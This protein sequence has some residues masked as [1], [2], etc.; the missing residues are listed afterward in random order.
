MKNIARVAVVLIQPEIPGN[1]GTIGRL[2]VGFN[3]EL[4]LIRP[5]GFQI[6]DKSVKRAGLDYWPHLN[7]HI[8]DSWDQ[9]LKNSV[10]EFQQLVLLSKQE[11]YGINDFLLF[12]YICCYILFI[13]HPILKRHQEFV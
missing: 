5:L 1:T 3:C 8:H 13:L 7:Y 9:F 6:D 2:C 11:K 10:H 4:H 12:T